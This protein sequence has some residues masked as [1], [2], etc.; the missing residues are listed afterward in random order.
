LFTHE[1]KV[2]V[3]VV[4]WVFGSL[5]GFGCRVERCD[6]VL[7]C[8]VGRGVGVVKV[9]RRLLELMAVQDRHEKCSAEWINLETIHREVTR[10]SLR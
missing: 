4:V 5:V 6:V 7:L 10:L 8:S 9:G 2:I 1:F 3:V